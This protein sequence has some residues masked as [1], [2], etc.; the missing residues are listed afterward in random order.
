MASTAICPGQPRRPRC[1]EQ[2]FGL[3]GRRGEW[4]DWKEKS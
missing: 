4:D 2:S 3:R 1:K